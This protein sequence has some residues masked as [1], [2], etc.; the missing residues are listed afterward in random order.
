[1]KFRVL[2]SEVGGDALAK[3]A[4]H[5]IQRRSYPGAGARVGALLVAG[6]QPPFVARQVEAT[7]DGI[8]AE[9][10]RPRCKGKRRAGQRICCDDLSLA[11]GVTRPQ[12]G[13]DIELAPS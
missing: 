9:V 11:V 7:I 2:I 13:S 8:V 5:G 12:I 1:R 10:D 3:I 6:A 4:A